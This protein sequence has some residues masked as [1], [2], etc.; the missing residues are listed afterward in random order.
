MKDARRNDPSKH[1]ENKPPVVGMK[2]VFSL[3]ELSLFR[4]VLVYV[5]QKT[6]EQVVFRDIHLAIH[7]FLLEDISANHMKTYR[8]REPS[9]ALRWML[10]PA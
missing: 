10:A 1:P 2:K 3:K 5:D 7:D 9:N 4:G 6:H 8:L